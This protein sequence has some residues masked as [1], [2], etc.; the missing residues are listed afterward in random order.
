M[1]SHDRAERV[2]IGNRQRTRRTQSAAAATESAAFS[3]ISITRLAI[4]GFLGFVPTC[5]STII[6]FALT[7]GLARFRFLLEDAES[8][9]FGF[10]VAG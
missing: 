2:S 8:I 5:G 6:A 9:A 3:A 4:F 1:G 7:A 10:S